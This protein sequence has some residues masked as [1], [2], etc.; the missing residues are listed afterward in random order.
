M[1]K[2]QLQ[3]VYNQE[4]EEEI[5]INKDIEK[6]KKELHKLKLSS[7]SYRVKTNL[8]ISLMILLA[9]SK[10]GLFFTIVNLGAVKTIILTALFGLIYGVSNLVYKSIIYKK[11]GVNLSKKI[12]E[13][14]K[15][16]EEIDYN[17][18]LE[19]AKNIE[20]INKKS[21]TF[22]NNKIKQ[23]YNGLP[24]FSKN[25]FLTNNELKEKINELDDKVKE[26]TNKVNE[27]IEGHAVNKVAQNYLLLN[28]L[29]QMIINMIIGLVIIATL[30]LLFNLSVSFIYQVVLGILL[31]GGY[32]VSKNITF[33]NAKE[34]FDK[35]GINL[36]SLKHLNGLDKKEEEIVKENAYLSNS[37][38]EQLEAISVYESL[39][40]V[41]VVNK[42]ANNCKQMTNIETNS[43]IKENKGK[44]LIKK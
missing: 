21:L 5:N 44:T 7:R 11:Y 24:L 12:S 23:C 15:I 20:N 14:D 38:L 8:I 26:N 33:N 22:L 36:V 41:K 10:S 29:S 19:Q 3:K 25:Y 2:D 28:I 17:I 16:N 1:Q 32:V 18:K 27:S 42:D 6:Y 37:K 30:P 13:K 31:F 34:V 9:S 35:Y 40:F 4:R 39:P 43:V